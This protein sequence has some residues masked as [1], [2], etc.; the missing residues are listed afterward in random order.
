[1]E[2]VGKVV[3]FYQACRT[4]HP[5]T[6][7]D[8]WKWTQFLN[9]KYISLSEQTDPIVNWYKIVWCRNHLLRYAIILWLTYWKR[10]SIL[11]K[12]LNWDIITINT[13]VL[14]NRYPECHEHLF[15]PCPYSAEF[16]RSILKQM[17]QQDII[18]TWQ[19]ILDWLSQA[20]LVIKIQKRL[21][22]I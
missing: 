2:G 5:R 6:G 19:D 13:C 11:D 3:S 18:Y 4:I 10:I 9:H 8:Q 15:F 22:A 1:M 21:A 17:M 12:L 14:C 7:P 20:K 16:Q